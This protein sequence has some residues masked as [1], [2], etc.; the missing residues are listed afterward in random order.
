MGNVIEE[1]A[2]IDLEGWYIGKGSWGDDV[3]G[4]IDAGIAEEPMV[5]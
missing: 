4:A 2:G 1:V 5:I 3:W